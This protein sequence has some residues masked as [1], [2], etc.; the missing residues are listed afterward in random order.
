MIARLVVATLLLLASGAALAQTPSPLADWQYSAGRVLEP[1]FQDRPAR[2]AK[3]VGVVGEVLPRYEGAGRYRVQ[4]GLIVDVRFKDVA[5][6]STSEGLGV[7]LFHD[8]GYRAGA[9]V[10]FDLGRPEDRDPVLT[11]MGDIRPSAQFKL[12]GEAVV[13]FPVVLRVAARQGINRRGG[14]VGDVSL[15]MPVSGSEKFFVMAGPSVSFADSRHMQTYFGVSP[16]QSL[17]SGHPAYEPGAGLEDARFG[18]TATW[19]ISKRWI[20]DTTGAAQWLLGDAAHSP[21]VQDQR[22]Y[23]LAMTFGYLW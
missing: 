17:T 13:Y 20:F 7:N 8:K 18:F 3:M 16:E 6:L 14:A 22:Q 9:A 15:Y 11:G 23:V 12:F 1:Y 2:W 19:I 5:F 21:L 10:A 4:P